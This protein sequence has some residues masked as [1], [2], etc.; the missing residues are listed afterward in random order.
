MDINPVDAAVGNIVD[1]A[2]DQGEAPAAASSLEDIGEEPSGL[3]PSGIAP[4][5]DD[6]SLVG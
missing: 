2:I 4:S 6:S 3:D 1:S 5:E